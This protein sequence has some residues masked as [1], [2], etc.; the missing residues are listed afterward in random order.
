[1]K[2]YI[3]TKI[4]QAELFVRNGAPGY[5]VIYPDGYE[6]WSP[7]KTFQDAY[8]EVSDAERKLLGDAAASGA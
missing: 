3:G 7:I 4:V 2:T 8:R 5:K 1:M 6:S